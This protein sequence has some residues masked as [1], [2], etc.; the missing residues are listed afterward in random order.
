MAFLRKRQEQDGTGSCFKIDADD[1]LG[2]KF[3]ALME[4]LTESLWPDGESRVTGSLTVFL[5]DGMLK[6]CVADKDQELVAFVAGVGLTS[7]LRALEEGLVGDGLD[8]RRP[9]ESGGGRPKKSH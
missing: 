5:Q 3:P 4:F 6:A 8:W 1:A 7:L 2:K 9:R